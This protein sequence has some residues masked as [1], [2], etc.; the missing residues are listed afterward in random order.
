MVCLFYVIY[1]YYRNKQFLQFLQQHHTVIF[2]PYIIYKIMTTVSGEGL[3]PN[4]VYFLPRL[5]RIQTPHYG[6]PFKI[7]QRTHII[8]LDMIFSSSECVWSNAKIYWK[9]LNMKWKV[10]S[11]LGIFHWQMR[12]VKIIFNLF[13]KRFY[14]C[15]LIKTKLILNNIIK[16]ENTC[17][18][19]SCL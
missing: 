5:M 17:L 4:I 15:D 18:K 19:I 7:F 13:E 8:G 6:K 2:H 1:S 3:R 11:Y 9:T 12:Y 10:I 16:I 14:S